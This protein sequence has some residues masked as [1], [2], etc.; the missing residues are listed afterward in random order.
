MFTLVHELAHLWLGATGVSDVQAGRVPEQQVERWCKQVA[1]E[2][3]P[4]R[5]LP[6]PGPGLW[7]RTRLPPRSTLARPQGPLPG[8]GGRQEPTAD[9][10]PR[11]GPE[12]AAGVLQ[13]PPGVSELRLRLPRSHDRLAGRTPDP[14]R[15]W[16]GRP[17]PPWQDASRSAFRS[18]RWPS[19]N[20]SPNSSNTPSKPPD[21]STPCWPNPAWS[22]CGWPPKACP[23][24]PDVSSAPPCSE[25]F[26][27]GSII[28][29]TTCCRK[30]CIQKILTSLFLCTRQTKD[31]CPLTSSQLDSTL[32]DFQTVL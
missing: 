18:S 9:V 30:P 26:P 3:R 21:A 8:T 7:C 13:R 32:S 4:H 11:R 23:D 10:D 15:P 24:K 12:P 16:A 29:L 25:P 19:E 28:S 1:A 14:R 2:L 22:C 20:A 17:L 27:R 31:M 5:P 6:Q